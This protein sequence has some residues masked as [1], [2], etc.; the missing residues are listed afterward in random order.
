MRF[1]VAGL[2]LALAFCGCVGASEEGAYRGAVPV[3]GTEALRTE[4]D[5]PDPPMLLDVRTPGEYG[6]G[7]IPG[8]VLVP[9]YSLSEKLYGLRRYTHRRIVTYCEIGARSEAAA[10]ILIGEGFDHVENYRAGMAE[11]R[12]ME[13]VERGGP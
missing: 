3:V 8:A 2:V 10:R 1:A 5:A 11:W 9:I 12:R 4:L 13:P 6:E 7:H